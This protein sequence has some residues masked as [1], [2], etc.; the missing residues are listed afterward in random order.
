MGIFKKKDGGFMDVI[1]C[2]EPSYLIWKWHPTGSQSSSNGRENAIRWGSSLRVKEGEV[3]VFFYSQENGII[4]DFIEGPFDQIIETANL[5]VLASIVGLA[6]DGA[7][8]F[9]AEVYFI[10]LAKIVQVKF[11]IPYFDVYDPRFKDFGVPVAVRGTISFSI[12]DYREF[13]KLH[14]L[15]T[16]SIEAF[17]IQIK[18]AVA[19]YIKEVVTNAPSVHNIPV[20]QIESKIAQ[21][22]DLIELTLAERLRESFGVIT[23]S[24]DISAIEIDK[25][26]DGYLQLMQVTKDVVSATMQ[27]EATAKIK[28]IHDKQ[29]IEIE[30][31][32]ANLK[33]QREESQ[34][35]QHKQTQSA[36]LAAFQIEKQAEVGIAGVQALGQMESNGGSVNLSGGD[37]INMA[38][39][40]TSM[41]IGGAIGQN[42]AG[43]INNMMSGMNQS[44]QENLT[45]PPI[46][47]PM[48]NIAIN[49][50]AKGPFDSETLR[51]MISTGE[52]SK[53]SLVWS[54]G[55]EN[56]MRM[57]EVDKIK[58]LFNNE[59]PPI[60][61]DN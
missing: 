10:N 59:V 39:M 18:D 44:V 23:S 50:Q 56:W 35:A 51:K 7:S 3:A 60:P 43:T 58:D 20:V 40:M 31:Y 21:I 4:Q 25:T 34:Y 5:P 29:R 8:P 30:D 26:S 27:A 47:T 49:G 37:G 41:A 33:I 2:D 16:F 6:Y 61:K 24:V 19:R 12:Q 17:Q 13:I 22:N 55:M 15:E 45:P 14:R 11:G 38:N 54:Q 46:K 52:L 9:N 57:A 32:E 48:Y 53:D 28:D 1:R 42:M 36:N